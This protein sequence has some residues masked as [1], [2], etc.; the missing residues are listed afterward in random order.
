MRILVIGEG[1][2]EHALLWKLNQ[3]KR[4]G[5]IYVA[6]GN[7]GTRQIAENIPIG[8]KDIDGLV[9]FARDKNIDLTVVGPEESLAAGIV[10][11]FDAK[12]LRIFGP[13]CAAARIETSKVFAKDF[14]VKEG[15]PTAPFRIFQEY[16][17]ALA[18]IREHGAPIVI[19][20][21]GLAR[22]KGVYPCKTLAQAEEALKKIFIDRTHG[23]AADEGVVIEEFLEGKELS[24]HAFCDGQTAVLMPPSQD[25]KPI[26]DGDKG[27]NTGGMGAF[28][29]VPWVTSDLLQQIKS[30]I[31]EPILRGLNKRQQPFIGCLYP[32]LMITPQGPMVLE[33]NARFGDP[34]G[35]IYLRLLKTDLLEILEACIERRLANITIEWLPGFAVDIVIASEGYP[36]DYK[37]NLPI[38]GI[39]EAEQVP[40]VVVFH[41]GTAYTDVLRSS[42]GRVMNIT[43]IGETLEITLDRAYEAVKFIQLDGMQYRRDIGAK[44][45]IF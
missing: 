41:A 10:D 37:D 13:S 7:G 4:V 34:E 14:M 3:S 27:P 16:D 18:Y 44:A 29:P 11:S 36:G 45:F 2:R 6:P 5:K 22:G 23:E 8:T 24:I 33:I 38:Q 43:A 17:K 30:E 39:R 15:I 40:G 21:S 12:H 20:V 19:K 31:V 28:T 42:S 26:F 25:H 32:G 35:P 9:R 1:A